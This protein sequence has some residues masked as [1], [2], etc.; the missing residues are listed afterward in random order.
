LFSPEGITMKIVLEGEEARHYLAG[1]ELEKKLDTVIARLTQVE[2]HVSEIKDQL[3]AQ[4]ATASN[5]LSVARAAFVNYVAKENAEDVEQE[6]D[7]AAAVAAK[8][9]EI[10]ALLT[11]IAELEAQLAGGLSAEE[12]AVV[13]AEVA[14][15][16]SAVVALKAEIE[17]QA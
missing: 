9:A 6:A 5:D 2:A 11:R 1:L 12:A 15:L 16:V 4:L 10:D 13:S 8:Q 14:S 3:L 17:P 7:K